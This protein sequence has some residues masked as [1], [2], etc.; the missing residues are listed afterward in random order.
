MNARKGH[1]TLFVPGL[2]I[3]VIVMVLLFPGCAGL[4]GEI[5]SKPGKPEG[6]EYLRVTSVVLQTDIPQLFE[7][8][9]RRTL[10]TAIPME[11]LKEAAEDQFPVYIDTEGYKK[12]IEDL[13]ISF[14]PLIESPEFRLYRWGKPAEDGKGAAVV[15]VWL[16]N[17]FSRDMMTFFLYQRHEKGVEKRT[18]DISRVYRKE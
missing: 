15:V 1:S 5:N 7:E 12:D 14:N 4:T 10:L 18:V 8:K 2:M 9:N 3:F 6:R 16:T 13:S 17:C 11:E